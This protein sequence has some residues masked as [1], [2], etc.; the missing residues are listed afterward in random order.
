MKNTI[1][2]ILSVLVIGLGVYSFKDKFISHNTAKKTDV[3]DN[4]SLQVTENSQQSNSEI[5]KDNCIGSTKRD[6]LDMDYRYYYQNYLPV[7]VDILDMYNYSE[8]TGFK[9]D[10]YASD[11]NIKW[12]LYKYYHNSYPD[13]YDTNKE[14][15]SY[16]KTVTKSELDKLTYIVFAKNGLDDYSFSFREKFGIIKLDESTYRIVWYGTAGAT[17]SLDSYPY[18]LY[19]DKDD[20]IIES[21]VY[22]DSI[23]QNHE[24]IGF[25]KFKF[26]YNSEKQLYYLSSIEEIK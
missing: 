14:D 3:E 8:E 2:V 23:G 9:L 1:I 22:V 4:K 21:N 18:N 19:T 15:G 24:K 6:S 20:L 7:L 16:S 17:F 26:K 12:F 25:L 10:N 13:Q 5:N 11:D